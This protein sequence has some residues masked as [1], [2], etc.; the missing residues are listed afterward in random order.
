MIKLKK[1]ILKNKHYY[2]NIMSFILKKLRF[3]I[4]IILINS[5]INENSLTIIYLS[6]IFNVTFETT[7]FFIINIIKREIKR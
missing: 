1:M 2:F 4:V 7:N 3:A 6:F 5:I